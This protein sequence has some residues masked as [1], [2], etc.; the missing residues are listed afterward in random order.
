MRAL[1]LLFD[2][3]SSLSVQHSGRKPAAFSHIYGTS[4]ALSLTNFFLINRISIRQILYVFSLCLL[5]F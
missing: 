3:A 4:L 2:F 1:S 5:G